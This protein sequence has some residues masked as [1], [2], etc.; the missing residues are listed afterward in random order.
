MMIDQSISVVMN[1]DV[2]PSI[3]LEMSSCFKT[4]IPSEYNNRAMCPPYRDAMKCYIIP[5]LWIHWRFHFVQPRKW[6]RLFV[7]RFSIPIPK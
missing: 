3:W 7:Y 5:I 6:M 2:L 4:D 1:V